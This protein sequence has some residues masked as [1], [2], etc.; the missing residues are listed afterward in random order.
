ML[1]VAEKMVELEIGVP[2]LLGNREEIRALAKANGV[3]LELVRILEPKR[4]SDFSLFCERLERIERYKG[5]DGIN[6]AKILQNPQYYAAMMLQYGHADGCVSGNQTAPYGVFRPLLSLIKPNSTVPHVYSTTILVSDTLPH[7][8]KDGM[9]FLADTNMNI[10]PEVGELAA[11]AAET[12][13]LAHH[14]L[15]RQ[16]RVAM[17]SYSTHGSSTGASV[18]RMQAATALAREKVNFDEIQIDGELQADVALDAEA[19]ELK[20]P[21]MQRKEPADVLVFPSLDAA[22]ISAKLLVHVGGA[23][24]YGHLIMGLMRPAG[25]VPR[26]ASMEMILG[27]A[28]AVGA[29]AIKYRELHEEETHL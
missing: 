1:R 11:I 20:A 19:A 23:Q 29:E 10:D 27:T 6:A 2:I 9:L 18:Q 21:E 26:T 7:F 24:P 28:A 13:S 22:H 4:S 25:Q 17:L 12:G 15:G 3:G 8:G 14:F 16:V 5:N